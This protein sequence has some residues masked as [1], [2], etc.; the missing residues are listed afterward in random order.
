MDNFS[1]ASSGAKYEYPPK[2]VKI[3][4]DTNSGVYVGQN[5]KIPLITKIPFYKVKLF[6]VEDRLIILVW[7]RVRRNKNV[8]NKYY[9]SFHQ[10]IILMWRHVGQNIE[11][12]K[13][14]KFIIF[15]HRPFEWC[16]KC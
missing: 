12:T 3:L 15:K 13:I 10:W 16:I 11:N 14:T 5:I 1:V 6:I 2:H 4:T 7:L 9:D 8:H